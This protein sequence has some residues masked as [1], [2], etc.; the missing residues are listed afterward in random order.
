MLQNCTFIQILGQATP[1]RD[2]LKH[3]LNLSK[4][5]AEYITNSP[6]G[7]GLIYTGKNV[8][9]FSGNVPKDT[10]VYRLLTSNPRERREYELERQREEARK[11]KEAKEI[12]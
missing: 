3:I 4:A 5:N 6:P 1:D 9:P 11:Q 8:I 7:Q 12:A 2:S 10:K